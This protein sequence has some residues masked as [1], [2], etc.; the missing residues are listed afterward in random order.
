[1]VR[2]C[3]H[4]GIVAVRDGDYAGF[5]WYPAS[6]GLDRW[7]DLYSAAAR[8]NGGEPDAGRRLL[9]WAHAAGCQDLTA[10]SSTWCYAD[11]GSRQEWGGMWADRITGSA[12]AEQLLSSKLATVGELEAVADAW[13]AWAAEPNGWLSVLHGEILIRV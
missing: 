8:A 9:D 1:M 4:G 11:P 5:T 3:R 2:V 13:R 7:R 12:V 6:P 10:S